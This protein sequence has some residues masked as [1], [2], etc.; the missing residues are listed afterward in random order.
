MLTSN[1]LDLALAENGFLDVAFDPD[2][3]LVTAALIVEQLARLPYAVEAGASALVRPLLGEL[4]R[5]VCLI[6]AGAL[7]RP[8]RFLAPGATLVVLHPDKVV[9]FTAE[10]GEVKPVES[11]YAYPMAM[12]TP[13]ADRG[14][15][16]DA[17]ADRR[18]S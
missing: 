3:G 8:V 9:T 16:V 14:R 13:G 6:E 1:D 17:A 10:P 15:A 2:L 7:T 18:D 4:T 12:L 5:P 11:L